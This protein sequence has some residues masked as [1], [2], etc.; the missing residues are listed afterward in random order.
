MKSL[1]LVDICYPEYV[2]HKCDYAIPVNSTTT[3]L[4][5][6]EAL[7]EECGNDAMVDNF[8][9]NSDMLDSELVMDNDHSIE[10]TD[11]DYEDYETMYA[12]FVEAHS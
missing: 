5:L 7:L 10:E 6:C 9:I 8:M 11:E 3:F 4:A 1:K 2:Q 12:Y